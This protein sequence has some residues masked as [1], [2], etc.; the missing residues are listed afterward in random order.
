MSR[1][2]EAPASYRGKNREIP[3][4][5]HVAMPSFTKGIAEMTTAQRIKLNV[6]QSSPRAATLDAL[7]SV[8]ETPARPKEVPSFDRR[9]VNMEGRPLRASSYAVYVDLPGDQAEMLLVHSYT[10]AYDK[11][12][13]RVATYLRS[14][15]S[16]HAPKPL[17]GD[18]SP[19]PKVDGA[20][21]A[22]SEET[23]E[24]LKKR[25]Y[26][27]PMTTEEEEA[28]FTNVTSTFHQRAVHQ[29][30]GYILMPTY[31]C[32]LRC[33]YCFQ[34]HMR[35]DPAYGHLLRTMEPAMVDR[36]FQGMEQIEAAH[37]IPAG[38]EVM[39]N[40][41]LFGG[42]PLLRESR[43][44]IEYILNKAF[45]HGKANITAIT[46]ATDLDAY[47][48]LLGPG[49]ISFLQ[50]TLDGPPEEHDK[51]RIYAD[52]TGSFERIAKNVTMALERG[53]RISMRMNV[54][55]AN[56]THL[57]A[58]A[59]E[60][61]A[62]GW[63]AHRL[64]SAYVAPVHA[65]NEQTS[66][67]S[68]FNSWELNNAKA[69]HPSVRRLGGG[70]DSLLGKARKIFDQQVDPLTGFRSSFCGAHNSM[71]VVDAFGDL[72]ACW[73]RTGD[74][75]LRIGAIEPS[76]EVRMSRAIMDMWRN[77]SVTSNPVCR[78]CRYASYCGGGCAVLA[79]GQ[80]GSLYTNHC[81]GFGKRFRASVAEAYGD[82]VAG[83]KPETSAERVC[84]M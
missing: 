7:L 38:A 66:E 55:R 68:T 42:E 45:A 62:R 74:P 65:S 72:Y 57:P 46:N 54:D 12:S 59:D 24:R 10:G 44:I 64:F 40:I 13:R 84:D 69:L 1:S 58:L 21:L 35:T 2:I 47:E 20:V 43:P 33:S 52:G 3:A 36:I 79:E 30:P 48:D 15:D 50:V 23:I 77:R 76:G 81:D 16:G 71:Y 5:M 8:P 22:P 56:I 82:H 60:F 53:T 18:W 49:K 39:R 14:L 34:D 25:G 11:V 29:A 51:R 41:T 4:G 28:F 63:A 73:E 61:V 9:S 67:K 17:Y 31:Q 19:E 80:T 78:K 32:N 6:L 26:L 37:G 75:S 70:D 83:V 27:T